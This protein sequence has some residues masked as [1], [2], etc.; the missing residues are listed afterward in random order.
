MIQIIQKSFE[1]TRQSVK[2]Y[3]VNGWV[4]GPESPASDGQQILWPVIP[5][6]NGGLV[7][8]SMGVLLEYNELTAY[9]GETA[10]TEVSM[11][12]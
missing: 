8:S 4:S 1:I 11:F 10:S 6:L 5:I 9:N 3:A 2:K 12:Q 7:H